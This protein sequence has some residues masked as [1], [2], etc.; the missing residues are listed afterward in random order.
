METS[1]IDIIF[2]C[3]LA[4]LALSMIVFL[5]FFVPVLVQLTKVLESLRSLIDIGK[6]YVQGIQNKLNSAGQ[7]VGKLADYLTALGGTVGTAL[8]DLVFSNKRK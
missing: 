4:F 6:D 2:I 1:V 8:F 3:S 7:N 5:I